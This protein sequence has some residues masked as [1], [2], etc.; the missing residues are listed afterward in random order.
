MAPIKSGQLRF[1]QT[2]DKGENSGVD[3]AEREIALTI[4]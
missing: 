3:E 2:L 4:E 1:L